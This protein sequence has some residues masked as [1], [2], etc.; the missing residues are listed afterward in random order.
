[1][2]RVAICDDDKAVT[3]EIHWYLTQQSSQQ[4]VSKHISVYHSGE[5]FLRDVTEG[6]A[7]HI[8]FMDIQMDGING[9]K[10]GQILRN[11]PTGDEVILVY[12]SSH[13][14][15]Y[16]GIAYIGSFG[17]IKKPIVLE[18]LDEIFNRAFSLALKQV[19]N[20]KRMFLYKVNTEMH[21][22]TIKEIVYFRNCKRVI[23][24][25]A[26][27]EAKKE[28]FFL[29]KFYSNIA[30]TLKQLP[31]G[32]FIQCE[33]SY[34]VNLDYVKQMGRSSFSLEDKDRTSIPIGKTLKEEVKEAYF[35]RRG[36]QDE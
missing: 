8:V 15:Y 13:D 34:I 19:E 24:L 5:D 1:M 29:D 9:I 2:I 27:D 17:F 35:K 32:Q 23:E 6:E 33:R 14:S 12:M 21:S 28:V 25:Y 22:V 11:T 10:T 4:D 31:A 16:E 26:W 18:R 3:S 36:Q 20:R 30:E 7:F